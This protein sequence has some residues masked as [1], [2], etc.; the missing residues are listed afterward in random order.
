MTRTLDHIVD[1]TQFEK[2]Y[3]KQNTARSQKDVF[4]IWLVLMFIAVF[5]AH[6][7]LNF[8]GNTITG[9]VTATQDPAGNITALLYSMFAVFVV[10]LVTALI[11]TG[12][13][14]KD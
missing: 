4:F 8:S 10:V 13:T 2:S 9:F 6:F 14:Q 5:A 3:K 1:D 7:V 11:Y 12:I